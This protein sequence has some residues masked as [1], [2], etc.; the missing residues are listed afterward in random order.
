MKSSCKR[1]ARLTRRC[2]LS[3]LVLSFFWFF[4]RFRFR[5]RFRGKVERERRGECFFLL[6]L[7]FHPLPLSSPPLLLLLLS[8][9]LTPV[10]PEAVLGHVPGAF[11]LP[12]RSAGLLRQVSRP[13]VLEKRRAAA[14]LDKE[15]AAVLRGVEQHRRVVDLQNRGVDRGHAAPF[16]AGGVVEERGA[17]DDQRRVLHVDRAALAS[18]VISERRVEHADDRRIVGVEG[19]GR[20][21]VA[22]DEGGV[23]DGGPGVGE[24]DG[25]L[26]L[27]FF[28]FF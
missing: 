25:G 20:G 7:F 28:F 16:A 4:F 12:K 15:P 14:I 9:L 19:S 23:D 1:S 8:S 6:P 13:S 5:F 2:P 17:V 18:A 11:G 27:F 22:C 26:A 3:F 24:G 10:V 21:V